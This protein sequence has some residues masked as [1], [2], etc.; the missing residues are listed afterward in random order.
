MNNFLKSEMNFF[1]KFHFY[2]LSNTTKILLF[3]FI[4]LIILTIY[5]TIF[6]VNCFNLLY[7]LLIIF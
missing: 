2:V 7:L 5:Y 1:L 6:N 3:Y 4:E